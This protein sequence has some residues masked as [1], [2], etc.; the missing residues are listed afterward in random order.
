MF[1][2]KKIVKINISC[3]DQPYDKDKEKHAGFDN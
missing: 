2:L 1:L 3:Q